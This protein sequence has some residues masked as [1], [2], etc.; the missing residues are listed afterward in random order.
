M[1]TRHAENA[2]TRERQQNP[3]REGD[4]EA[5]WRHRVGDLEPFVRIGGAEGA[6]HH[7]HHPEG[8]ECAEQ[9]SDRRRREVV[10]GTLEREHL[11]EVAAPGADRPGNPE[12]AAALGREHD[13]DQEDEQDSC[14][15]R[16]CP[17]GREERR[18]RGAG[19][20]SVL[21]SILL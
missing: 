8:D 16:E 13:E 1:L 15:D 4:H 7:D 9:R 5:P 2:T 18:E 21:E 12:L 14:S 3:D 19:R 10:R 17:E 11:D 6:R 20:R